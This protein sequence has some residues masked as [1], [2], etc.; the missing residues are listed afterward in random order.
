MTECLE[1]ILS[2][3]CQ[4]I[5]DRIQV[6]EHSILLDVHEWWVSLYQN[7]SMKEDLLKYLSQGDSS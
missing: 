1:S 2:Q 5:L 4:Y 3:K 6:N 7:V